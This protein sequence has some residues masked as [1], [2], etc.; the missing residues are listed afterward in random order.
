MYNPKIP[1][2]LTVCNTQSRG[3]LNRP[4]SAVCMRTLIVSLVTHSQHLFLAPEVR[5]NSQW[6]SYGQLSQPREN[7]SH[8]PS[9]VLRGCCP[10]RLTLA[11]GFIAVLV[12]VG[13]L[14]R[15]VG[16]LVCDVVLATDKV[17]IPIDHCRHR[18]PQL[19]RPKYT[20]GYSS[21]ARF[22][23]LRGPKSR[24]LHDL[25][26]TCRA[27]GRLLSPSAGRLFC[28]SISELL[29]DRPRS[30]WKSVLPKLKMV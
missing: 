8:E 11:D 5:L 15:A 17:D 4:C 1:S 21:M 6:M 3:P 24:V 7:T 18:P 20:D 30:A 10:C 26:R 13:I 29:D 16:R 14:D 12:E 27:R 9:I 22:M 23:S 2:F 28:N 25:C 19:Q